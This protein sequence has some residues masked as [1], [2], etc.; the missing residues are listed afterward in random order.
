MILLVDSSALALVINPDADPPDDPET[1]SPLTRVRDRIEL[2]LSSLGV[3]D[4]IIVPTPVLAEILVKAGD[5]AP[6]V[7]VAL[8]SLARIKIVP[9]D[10]R[11]AVE[12]AMMTR[13]ALDAGDKRGG[14][15][16]AWQKVKIDRQIVAI[17]RVHGALKIYADDKGLVKFAATLGI[18]VVSSWGL[19]LPESPENLFTVAGLAASGHHDPRPGG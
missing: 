19:P 6:D 9:F 4:T 12:T 10:Q 2:L 7:L 1:R 17:A 14:S 11:A 16:Q 15:D 13:K 8:Q 18:D 5:S 3:G